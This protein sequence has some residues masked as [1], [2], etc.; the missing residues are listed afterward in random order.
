MFV[1][2]EKPEGVYIVDFEAGRRSGS[3]AGR[4]YLTRC[5][6]PFLAPV[7]SRIFL[8]SGRFWN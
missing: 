3:R 4:A 8:L 7:K 6:C 2:S 1:G 5:C